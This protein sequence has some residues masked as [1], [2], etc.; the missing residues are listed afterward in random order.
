MNPSDAIFVAGHRG[1]VGA[2][3]VRLLKARGFTNLL[4]RTR[5]ELD[6]KTEHI[7]F[8]WRDPEPVAP[9]PERQGDAPSSQGWALD[10]G[11]DSS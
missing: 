10:R 1:M 5:A 9:T 6:S 11:D 7:V 3:L 4:L 2:A 8:S